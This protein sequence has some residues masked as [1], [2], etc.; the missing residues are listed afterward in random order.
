MA[1]PREIRARVDQQVV[2]H[3]HLA[4]HFFCCH[5]LRSFSANRRPIVWRDIRVCGVNATT[6]SASNARVHRARPGGGVEHTV[7]MSNASS[8]PVSLRVPPAAGLP[9]EPPPDSPP[10]IVAWSG[11]RSTCPPAP[12]RQWLHRFDRATPSAESGRASPAAPTGSRPP[13]APPT[14]RARLPPGPR[15]NVRS[16]RPFPVRGSRRPGVSQYS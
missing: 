4:D 11:T 3:R 6:A 5:G 13:P 2:V 14:G 16:S 15:A 10:R 8:L 7:A 9:T 1:A 12:W